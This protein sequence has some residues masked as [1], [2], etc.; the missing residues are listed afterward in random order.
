MLTLLLMAWLADYTA[1]EYLEENGPTLFPNVADSMAQTCL[2]YLSFN[3]FK[4]GRDARPWS[5][6]DEYPFNLYAA[7][8]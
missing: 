8:H 4:Q 2:T 6:L 7:V 1:Q 3:V 5:L